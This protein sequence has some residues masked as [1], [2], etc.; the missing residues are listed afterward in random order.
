MASK[1]SLTKIKEL[2]IEAENKDLGFYDKWDFIAKHYGVKSDAVRKWYYRNLKKEVKELIDRQPKN[3][4]STITSDQWRT[5]YF[6]L[7]GTSS[8]KKIREIKIQIAHLLK[9]S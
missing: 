9:K 6:I 7:T 4:T 5:A 8:R 3:P 2:I 1:Y